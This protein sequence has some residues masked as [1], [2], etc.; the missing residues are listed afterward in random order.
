MKS[1]E[2]VEPKESK[3]LLDRLTGSL[4]RLLANSV[5]S[6][7]K[8]QAPAKSQP[9]HLIVKKIC[10]L[11]ARTGKFETLAEPHFTLKILKG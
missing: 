9:S 1:V 7:H 4:T 8:L 6:D 10:M 11:Q 3:T 2:L 5:R